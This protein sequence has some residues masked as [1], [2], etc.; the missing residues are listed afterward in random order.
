MILNKRSPGQPKKVIQE[1]ATNAHTVLGSKQ[2]E[3]VNDDDD[4]SKTSDAVGRSNWF[5]TPLIH[6]ILA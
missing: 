2:N 3:K 5:A 1:D 4:D 6:D